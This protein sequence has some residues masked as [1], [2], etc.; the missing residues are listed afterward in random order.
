MSNRYPNASWALLNLAQYTRSR[1]PS[2]WRGQLAPL[3]RRLLEIESLLPF[4]HD[5]DRTDDFFAPALSRARCLLTLLESEPAARWLQSWL[6]QDGQLEPRRT[7]RTAHEGGLNFT[8][9]WGLWALWAATGDPRWRAQYVEHIETHMQQPAF[10][11]EDYDR[12]SHWVPQFGIYAIA[13]SF[14]EAPAPARS[15]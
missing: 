2:G 14:P 10:W 3:T 4:D 9:A 8:R 1:D 12:F 11:A 15:Q 7:A 13:L 5:Q 6:P